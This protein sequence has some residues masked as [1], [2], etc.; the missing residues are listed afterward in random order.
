[1][2]KTTVRDISIDAGVSTATV[3]R[4]LNG[5]G[6]T[7]SKAKTKVMN[8]AKKLGYKITETGNEE[9]GNT[10]LLITA[11]GFGA[12]TF[13]QVLSGIYDYAEL[14]GYNVV[15]MQSRVTSGIDDIIPSILSRKQVCGIIVSH[16]T[17]YHEKIYKVIGKNIP[18]VQCSEYSEAIP[19]PYVSINNFQAAYDVVNFLN[20]SGR[21]N[22][23]LLNHN[24]STLFS[25]KREEGFRAAM[26]DLGLPARTKWIYNLSGI[27]DYGQALNAAQQLLSAKERPD[28]V[29]AVSD[30]YA[31]AILRAAKQLGLSIPDDLAIVGFDNSEISKMSEPA[32][33]TV[34]QP[35]YEIGH[36][37]CS[38]L[39]QMIN[40]HGANQPTDILLNTE[41]IVRS[42]T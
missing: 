31:M 40:E 17:L 18:I 13:S 10:I 8:S 14:Y 39:T 34:N 5:K 4:V 1:M 37:T 11:T 20:A 3:S 19:C 27:Y 12:S 26:S 6:A 24:R 33:T 35:Y 21:K 32:L 28:A 16:V 36:S 9:I 42:T 7:S 22:I 30:V 25:I 38:I 29:F 23:A 41:L 15:H 2:P